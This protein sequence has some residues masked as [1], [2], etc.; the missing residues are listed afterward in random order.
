MFITQHIAL[1][2]A[3]GKHTEMSRPVLYVKD[4]SLKTAVHWSVTAA[5]SGST[6][7]VD[8]VDY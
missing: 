1:C 5:T 4:L 3:K 6:L 8:Q 2:H 7:A